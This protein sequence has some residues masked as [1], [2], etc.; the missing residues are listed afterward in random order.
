M[1]QITV[2]FI[3]VLILFYCLSEAAEAG[4]CLTASPRSQERRRALRGIALRCVSIRVCVSVCVSG[5]SCGSLISARRV[6]SVVGRTFHEVHSGT[7]QTS[8]GDWLR[9]F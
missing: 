5:V 1:Q 7:A 2:T 8:A 6:S 3:C 9:W 4:P